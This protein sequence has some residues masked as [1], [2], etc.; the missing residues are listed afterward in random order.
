MARRFTEDE[1]IA[2]LFAP[3]AGAAGL[4]LYDDAALLPASKNPMV[5]TTDAL[6]AG[7]HFFEGD[8]PGLIA[9]KALRV[10]LSDLAAKGAEP[11]GFLLAVALP[12]DWTNDW[13]AAFAAGLGEDALAYRCPLLGGDT[14]S[15][16]G[17]LTL[18]ITALGEAPEGRFVARTTAQAGDAVYVSG[19]VGDA[20]LG[21]R[22]RRDEALAR[23][24]STPARE[25]L[26]ERYLLPRPRLALAPALGLYASAAMDVSDGLAGDFAKFARASK[27]GARILLSSAPLSDAAREAIALD[28]SLFEVAMTGGDDYEILCSAGAG[29]AQLEAAAQAVGAPCARIGEFIEGDQETVF[30]DER[31]NIIH[32]N[33]LSFSHF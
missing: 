12:P 21:L 23:R 15:T 31:R 33:A 4:G 5:A 29:A 10:N 17:P 32:F 16:P 25:H 14:V 3:L 2:K 18:S 22:L 11:V 8:P 30:L 7:V 13:L 20:A 19:T 28:P 9:K 24:L 26:L 27:L 1:L 6:V